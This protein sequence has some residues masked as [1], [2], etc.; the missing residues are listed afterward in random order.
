MNNMSGR[1]AVVILNW[2][3]LEYLKKFLG[4]VVDYSSSPGTAIFVVDNGSSDHSSDW[5]EKNHPSVKIIRLEKNLGFAEGYNVAL[6]QISAEYYILLNSDIEVTQGWSDKLTSFMDM[7]PDAAACQPKILSWNDNSYFE[8]AGAAG[9]FLDK[10]GYPFCRGRAFNHT[11]QD[12]GQYDTL[13]EVLWTSGACMIVRSSAWHECS[14]FDPDFFAHMEE[15]DLCWRF[16][17]AGYSLYFYPLSVVYH[18]GGGVLPYGSP[19]KT[20]LNFRNNLFLLYKNLPDDKLHKVLFVRKILDGIA[21]IVFL[22][23]G[24]PG[25]LKAVWKAHMDYYKSI[26]S[27]KTKRE[28]ILRKYPEKVDN[29]ILNKSLIFEFYIRRRKTYSKIFDNL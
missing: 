7:N 13:K 19:F 6:R 12:N 28:K 4:K 15:I 10:Y 18:V 14:G 22:L 16:L 5:V 2:N 26:K 23:S 8:Y 25:N 27:L 29:L 21:G 1:T 17:L 9:G 3:G 11:E 20:Y 24:K